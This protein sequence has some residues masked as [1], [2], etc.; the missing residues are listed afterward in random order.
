SAVQTIGLKAREGARIAYAWIEDEGDAPGRPDTGIMTGS[1]NLE[2]NA[3]KLRG[4]FDSTDSFMS[5][6]TPEG[7][8]IEVNK[9][10]LDAAKLKP[11]DVVGKKFWD[12]YWWQ[13]SSQTQQKVKQAVVDASKGH[14]S[15]FEV[16][17][18]TEYHQQTTILFSIKPVYGQSGD[19]MYLLPEG[20]P[21]QELVDA[22]NRYQSIIEGTNV[23]TW[24]WNVQTGETR[25]NERWANIV[26]YTLEE[27]GPVN[28]DTWLS[29]AHPDDLPI[30]ELSLQAC[31]NRQAEFYEVECRMRHKDGHWVWVFDRGKVFTWTESGKPLMMFG[32]H[33]DITEQKS[34]EFKLRL[35][36]ES[37][38]NN[39]HYAGI[40]MALVDTD[41]RWLEVNKKLCDMLGYNESELHTLTFQD[42]TVAEDLEKDLALFNEVICAQRES[43]QVEKRY[44]HKSGS[45]VYALLSVAVVRNNDGTVKNFISQII[46][47]SELRQAQAHVSELLE[48]SEKQNQ[49]LRETQAKLEAA[50]A[51]LEEQSVTDPL[52]QLG[53]RRVLNTSLDRE[54]QRL[55][56][57][58]PEQGQLAL[59]MLDVDHFKQYNDGFGHI[60]G[61]KVLKKLAELLLSNCRPYD[62]VTRFGGEEFAIILPE[63][64]SSTAF[65]LAE[66]LRCIAE[67]SDWPNTSVTISIGLCVWVSGMTAYELVKFA[68]MALYGAK[69]MGRNQVVEWQPYSFDDSECDVSA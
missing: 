60:E 33:Q 49:L 56:R 28:I 34:R 63:T 55:K 31:F 9:T 21:I 67:Q 58:Q 24:Q 6:L 5:F 52:T 54:M 37:F 8:V 61:D 36:E 2:Q 57:G 26:G 12:C 11:Q 7:T 27:L 29:L 69:A 13:I 23:G 18:W 47:I 39:F 17:V 22:R 32:T 43:Y 64:D 3:R 20:R 40:G 14:L 66:R 10:A 46:D 19:L 44:Y 51:I 4:I 42:I 25:F 35:S 53:N 1:V 48:Q 41:G 16:T 50:N 15:R 45:V 65:L 59:I 68:D 62:V 38:S 30:S